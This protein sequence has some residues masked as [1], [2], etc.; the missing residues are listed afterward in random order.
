VA[1]A[2]AFSPDRRTLAVS[3]FI[4]D[5]PHC[6]GVVLFDANTGRKKQ[7]LPGDTW[8]VARAIAFSPDGRLAAAVAVAD[9]EG[10]GTG[11]LMLW[12]ASTG[13]PICRLDD[14]NMSGGARW[15][16]VHDPLFFF[17][18]GRKLVCGEHYLN[19]R[20]LTPLLGKILP[21][22]RLKPLFPAQARD[23]EDRTCL[24]P[25]DSSD[26]GRL[27]FWNRNTND[28]E[29]WNVLPH[30]RSYAWHPIG[31]VVEVLGYS[32]ASHRLATD[33]G[34]GNVSLWLL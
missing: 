14:E 31:K 10:P 1:L 15:G 22:D 6:P 16:D 7:T 19:L 27:V 24:G 4:G 26:D 12:D 3:G 21:H 32:A 23:P 13:K 33:D 2:I 34:Y 11:R 20:D 29:V 30:R 25:Y 28:I 17:D 5:D 18:R 9:G 8:D